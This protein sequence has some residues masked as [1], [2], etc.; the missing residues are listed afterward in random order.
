MTRPASGLGTSP[1]PEGDL[2]RGKHAE[3]VGDAHLHLPTV[4]P[5]QDPN[6]SPRA[7]EL[8]RVLH[9]IEEEQPQP[10]AVRLQHG[11]VVKG[12]GMDA[13]VLRNKITFGSHLTFMLPMIESSHLSAATC[14]LRTPLLDWTESH[15]V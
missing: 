15:R 3:S 12:R 10:L 9:E 2:I 13:G 6:L 5:R 14:A 4:L 7:V 8:D 11:E 1:G